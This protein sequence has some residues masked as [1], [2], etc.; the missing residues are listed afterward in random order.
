MCVLRMHLLS[1]SEYVVLL[2]Y[3]HTHIHINVYVFCYW[4]FEELPEHE[5]DRLD[6]DV[7]RAF[8]TRPVSQACHVQILTGHW[9]NLV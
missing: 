2:F 6:G 1:T 5:A 3:T 8:P 7:R 4:Y 9:M